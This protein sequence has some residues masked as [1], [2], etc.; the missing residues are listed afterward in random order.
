M[1]TRSA[2]SKFPLFLEEM[3]SYAGTA[4]EPFAKILHAVHRQLRGN[5][6]S[7]TRNG[8]LLVSPG[9]SSHNYVCS[10]S[11]LSDFETDVAP[12]HP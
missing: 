5:L 4:A 9:I 3:D 12:T 11:L 1:L 10:S 6:Q 8:E 7:L 2:V